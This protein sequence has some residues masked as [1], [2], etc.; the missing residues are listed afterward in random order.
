MI[1]EFPPLV[2]RNDRYTAE[3]KVKLIELFDINMKY[4][5]KYGVGNSRRK[6]MQKY[7]R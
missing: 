7:N 5:S 1:T 6:F 3:M 2:L 4:I